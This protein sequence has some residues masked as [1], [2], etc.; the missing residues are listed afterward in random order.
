MHY[1]VD[2]GVLQVKKN[3]ET[4]VCLSQ[5]LGPGGCLVRLRSQRNSVRVRIP[6]KNIIFRQVANTE[7]VP[8]YY[9]LC[10]TRAP[11]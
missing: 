10:C 4:V 5:L 6:L 11:I 9:G 2:K 1:F 8:M 3:F 7:Q